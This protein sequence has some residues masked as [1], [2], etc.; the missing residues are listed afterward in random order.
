ML[1]IR[2]M[3]AGDIP[4]GLRLCRLAH[5]NQTE[6]DWRRLLALEPGGVFV[7]EIDGR[8]CGT[9]GTTCYDTRTAWIG[10]VLVHPDFRRRG[11]A[12]A[13][14][15]HCLRHLQARGAQSIKLDATDQGRPVYLRLGFNDERPVYRYAG[16]RPQELAARPAARGIGPSDWAAI[17]RLD[18][19]AFGADRLRL[20]KLLA[21]DGLSAAAGDSGAVRAYGF[22]RP[23][24]EAS[25]LGPVV[26]AD[27]AAARN[28]VASLL[29][30]L[31]RAPV[32]WDVLPNNRDAVALAE[33]L[34]LSAGRRLTRMY[35]GATMNPGDVSCVYAAAGFELG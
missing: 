18:E 22:A 7:A 1:Q 8:P 35:R 25:H 14:M 11:V 30:R 26:A 32:I 29:A 23:G 33:G 24:H 3:Q 4:F 15:D 17:G 9:A 2:T 31:P 10:M 27:P 28:V 21:A 13:L 5:W 20:L 16:V 12:S 19:V 6:A 34:G